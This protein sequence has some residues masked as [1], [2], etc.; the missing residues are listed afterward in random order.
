MLKLDTKF[1][2]HELF[3]KYFKDLITG[4]CLSFSLSQGEISL[5]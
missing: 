5:K 4:N 1:V 3:L 2:F